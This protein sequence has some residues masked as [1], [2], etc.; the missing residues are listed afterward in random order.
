MEHHDATINRRTRENYARSFRLHH[1]PDLGKKRLRDL[2]R[3]DVR[4]ALVTGRF[5]RR[6]HR[7]DAR[8]GQHSMAYNPV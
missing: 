2:T 4:T 6:G 7:N 5:A 1:L 8:L 3:Q